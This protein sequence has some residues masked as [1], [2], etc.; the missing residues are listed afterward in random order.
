M[1]ALTYSTTLH[2]RRFEVMEKRVERSKESSPVCAPRGGARAYDTGPGLLQG[3]VRRV[4]RMDQPTGG[5][6]RILGRFGRY[7]SKGLPD[8]GPPPARPSDDS[9]YPEK[10]A[11]AKA[12]VERTTELIRQAQISLDGALLSGLDQPARRRDKK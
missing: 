9:S 6:C 1:E 11:Q 5:V 12:N 10:V 3:N 2:A 4:D 8:A 7:I